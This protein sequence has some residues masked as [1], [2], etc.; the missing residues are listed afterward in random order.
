MIQLEDVTKV[1]L[2]A[3]GPVHALSG[4]SLNV[5]AGEFVAVRGPSGCGKSTLLTVVG[6]LGAPS[7]GRVRVAGEDLAGM[8]S[9][10]RARFRAERVGFVFQMFHLLPYL[11]VLENVLAAAPAGC[12]AAARGRAEELLEGFQL[13]HRLRHRPG[14]LSTGECQRVAI[15]R[16]MVN[17]PQLILADEPT[18]N[19]DP[20]NSRGVMD[21]LSGFHREGGTML[22][23]TH[24]Q[25]AAEYAQRTILLRS[26]SVESN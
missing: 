20:E 22:L 8:S 9:A 21:L 7:T 19:L 5:A 16:A 11:N 18:G 1:Y 17:R 23:V 26:G 15:A 2:T 4:V 10:E 24:Q 3:Q 13:G 12:E 6:G 14:Q 25:L